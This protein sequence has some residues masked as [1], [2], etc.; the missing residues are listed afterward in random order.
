MLSPGGCVLHCITSLPFYTST[1]AVSDLLNSVLKLKL[2]F[3][4][5]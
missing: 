1:M 2:G 4:N 3:I 5:Q